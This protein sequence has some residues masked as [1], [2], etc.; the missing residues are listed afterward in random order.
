M[1]KTIKGHNKKV[2]LQPSNQTRKCNWR[3]KAKCPVGGNSHVNDVVYKYD[4]TTRM[5]EWGGRMEELL[6]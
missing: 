2:T 5:K 6:L 3:K 4:V 1:S